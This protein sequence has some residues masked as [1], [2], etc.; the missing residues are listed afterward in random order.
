MS[1]ATKIVLG[2]ITTAFVVGLVLL[3][4]IAAV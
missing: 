2:T 4:A 3:V 1:R